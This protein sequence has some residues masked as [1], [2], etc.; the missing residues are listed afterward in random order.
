M[1]TH[2]ISLSDAQL[3]GI[4]KGERE[5]RKNRSTLD[6]V[7]DG[8]DEFA[9]I[10]SWDW[11]HMQADFEALDEENRRLLRQRAEDAIGSLEYMLQNID[12]TLA[13]AEVEA[14]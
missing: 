2:D 3:L 5:R 9:L 6:I 11:R 7:D 8:L 14:N 4:V 1:P 10:W 12:A 13:R